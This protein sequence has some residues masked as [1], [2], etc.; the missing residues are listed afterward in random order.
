MAR[1][2]ERVTVSHGALELETNKFEAVRPGAAESFNGK[3]EA[4]V[5]MIGDGQHA[6]R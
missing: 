6:A 3:R 1:R 4:L 5:G 2:P